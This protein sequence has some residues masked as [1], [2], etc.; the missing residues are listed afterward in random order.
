MTLI[1]Q[2]VSNELLFFCYLIPSV[3]L[4]FSLSNI[5][6]TC[7]IISLFTEA[8]EAVKAKRSP[9]TDQKLS[10]RASEYA[11]IQYLAT[12]VKKNNVIESFD[13]DFVEYLLENGANINHFNAVG[14]TPF[15]IVAKYWN[16]DVARFLLDH[17][18]HI[19]FIHDI[20]V[21]TSSEY[22]TCCILT[23]NQ[24]TVEILPALFN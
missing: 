4:S 2:N 12:L 17:G 21:D 13:F 3:A 8:P 9:N 5:R 6:I 10:G 19:C 16:I 23:V 1:S 24:T 7:S 11:L 15:H 18:R 20:Y 14:Q 22:N